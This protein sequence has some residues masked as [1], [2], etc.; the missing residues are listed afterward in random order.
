MADPT[1]LELILLNLA[2]NAK[3]AMADGG[4]IAI[5]AGNVER[6]A[7]PARP[8]SPPPGRYVAISVADTGAGMAPEVLERVFEPFFTTKEVGRG[9]GLG[10]PQV[11]GVVKQLGG[12][13]EIATVLGEGS[14]VTVFLPRA[15]SAAVAE[16]AP[17]AAAVALK[18]V[19][20]LL[21]DDD[22]DVRGVAAALLSELGCRVTQASSGQAGLSILESG[23]GFDL[24]LLDYAM[25]GLN[26][27]ET[28]Q[29]IGKS[30]P[31]LPVMMISGYADA[32]AL[33]A[34]WSGPFLHKPFGA[35][36]LSSLIARTLA[37][38]RRAQPVSA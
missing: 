13:V 24:V 12:G 32:E 19:K 28:A 17:G 23:A 36:A 2:I 14:T 15:D 35:G 20:I 25:P 10:L 6:V 11:L 30:W 5:K 34:A 33:A 8:E 27:G 3:D 9:S 7:P 26:G 16:E 4:V 1:Q 22:P 21:I 37:A 31:G 29:R 18:G 38:S